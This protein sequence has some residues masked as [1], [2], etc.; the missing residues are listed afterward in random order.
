MYFIFTISCRDNAFGFIDVLCYR[1]NTRDGKRLNT[2][3]LIIKNVKLPNYK[4]RKGN[5]ISMIL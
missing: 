3:S 5:N 1:D 4:D 2:H